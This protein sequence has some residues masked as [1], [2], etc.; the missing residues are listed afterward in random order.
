MADSEFNERNGVSECVGRDTPGRG[1]WLNTMSHG[2][3]RRH[4]PWLEDRASVGRRRRGRGVSVLDRRAI[5][6][7]EVVH[8]DSEESHAVAFGFVERLSIG[9]TIVAD[10][11]G[12]DHGAGAVGAT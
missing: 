2:S 7:D 10:T 9:P 12:G 8:P 4:D 6:A 3:A 11:I 5:V 1:G